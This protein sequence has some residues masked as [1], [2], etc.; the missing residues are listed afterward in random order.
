MRTVT[1]NKGTCRRGRV[2]PGR[3]R[4]CAQAGGLASAVF[5]AVLLGAAPGAFAAPVE[6]GQAKENYTWSSDYEWIQT[7]ATS[8]SYAVP[9]KGKLAG[10]K[11]KAGAAAG[12]MQFEVWSPAGDDNYTLVYIS[13]P[14]VLTAGKITHVQLV[15]KLAVRAG[16]LLGYRST[17][18]VNCAVETE[19]TSDTYVYNTS[20][21]TPTVGTTVP[22][23]GGVSGFQFDI[24]A[25]FIG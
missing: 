18:R 23:T 15:P 17:T 8:A 1:G 7:A 2:A 9:A 12:T 24:A 20:G 16:D 19:S 11:T 25:R 6:L 3:W 4:R 10:W 13:Q 5:T 22:F 21:T 14:T